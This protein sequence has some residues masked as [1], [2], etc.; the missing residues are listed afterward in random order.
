MSCPTIAE[1]IAYAA[2][3]ETE[4]NGRASRILSVDK[5]YPMD[6]REAYVSI[7]T[8]AGYDWDIWFQDNG[9]LYG[10]C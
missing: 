3:L 6:G 9:K 5:H 2:R 1:A 10:E 7:E 8:E 4:W